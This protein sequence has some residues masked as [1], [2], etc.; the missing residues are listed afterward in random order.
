MTG[1]LDP[2]VLIGEARETIVLLADDCPHGYLTF[3]R[4][5][6]EGRAFAEVISWR[7]IGQDKRELGL[8]LRHLG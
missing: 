7:V 1:D 5:Y 4:H 6:T 8:L 2:D 3:R